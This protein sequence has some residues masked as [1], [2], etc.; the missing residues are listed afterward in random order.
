MKPGRTSSRFHVIGGEVYTTSS[1]INPESLWP[2]VRLQFE[3]A[4][5]DRHCDITVTGFKI[6]VIV[7]NYAVINHDILIASGAG[8]IF[9]CR[10]TNADNQRAN[11]G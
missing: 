4:V 8:V 7:R 1:G 11:D 2:G 5:C 9:I 10:S 3:G 6:V